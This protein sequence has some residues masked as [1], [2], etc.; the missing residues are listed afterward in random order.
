MFCM[1][2]KI[3][4]IAIPPTIITIENNAFVRCS[5]L[6]HIAIP[7][8]VSSFNHH[9]FGNIKSIDISGDIKQIPQCMF[10]GCSIFT[11]VTISSSVTSIGDNAFHSCHFLEEVNLP[12]S[13]ISI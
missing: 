5:S 1:N 13:L 6:T 12:S 4:K 9:L 8:S 11:R 2:T 10:A 7:S 3:E